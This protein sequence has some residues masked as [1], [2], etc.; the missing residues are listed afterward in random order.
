MTA[1]IA[2]AGSG[3][4]QVNDICVALGY[5]GVSQWGGNCGDV[6]GYCQTDTSCS[7]TG[8]P[9]FTGSGGCTQKTKAT[10]ALGSTVHWE[11]SN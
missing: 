2:S 9:T 1:W 3:Q 7:A 4:Y 8:N 6:C 11:C 5:A 10:C